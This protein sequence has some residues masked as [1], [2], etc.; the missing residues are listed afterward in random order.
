MKKSDLGETWGETGPIAVNSKESKKEKHYPSLNLNTKQL[1]ELKGYKVGDKCVLEVEAVVIGIRVNK[2]KKGEKANY[3]LELK[4]AS[5]EDAGEDDEIKEAL[6][7]AD[8]NEGKKAPKTK[9]GYP[10][11]SQNKEE[12]D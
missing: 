6:D 8:K 4:S 1:P 11:T 12:D 9:G 2:D 3:D 5:V 10:L 7:M